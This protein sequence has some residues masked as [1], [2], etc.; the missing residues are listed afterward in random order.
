MQFLP[1][2]WETWGSDGDG[3]GVADPQDLDDAAYST[4]RY[5][6]ASGQDLTTAAGWTAAIRSYNHSDDY[7]RAVYAAASAYADRAS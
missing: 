1:S 5:L 2:T 7:V 4:A 6:C 3:D